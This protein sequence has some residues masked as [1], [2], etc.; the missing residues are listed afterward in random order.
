[1]EEEVTRFTQIFGSLHPEATLCRSLKEDLVTGAETIQ[2]GLGFLEPQT[3]AH[4]KAKQHRGRR[5]AAGGS[6]R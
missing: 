6:G 3:G 5:Q 4:A 2:R 1:M